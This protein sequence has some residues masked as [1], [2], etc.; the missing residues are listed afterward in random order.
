MGNGRR[1]SQQPA[2]SDV[3]Y[4]LGNQPSNARAANAIN[5]MANSTIDVISSGLFGARGLAANVRSPSPAPFG[6]V[7]VGFL[8]FAAAIRFDDVQAECVLAMRGLLRTGYLGTVIYLRTVICLGTVI[9]LGTVISN[10]RT[11]ASS[12]SNWSSKSSRW[13]VSDF[14]INLISIKL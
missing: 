4:T 9:Y 5:Q 2:I 11:N 6:E 13:S 14:F 12:K 1:S 7:P 8:R 10:A 3:T